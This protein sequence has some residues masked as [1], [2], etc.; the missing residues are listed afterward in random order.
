M[1]YL[2]TTAASS[3]MNPPRVVQPLD[4]ARIGS[5]AGPLNAR[6]WLYASTD[7]STNPFTAGWFVDGYQLGMKEGDVVICVGRTS[8]VTSSQW[9]GIG[10]VS[11][12]STTGGGTQLST[13]SFISST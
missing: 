6:L 5:S 7:T 13:F 12:V 10:V 4:A 9:L 2:G 11:S 1:S 8:T 3:I